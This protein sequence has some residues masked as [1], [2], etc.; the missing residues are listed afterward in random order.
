MT[1]HFC[2]AAAVIICG[3]YGL[4]SAEVATGEAPFRGGQ[5]LHCKT[6]NT[7]HA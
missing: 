6:I 3:C 1:N 2:L 7:Q 5:S 4:T